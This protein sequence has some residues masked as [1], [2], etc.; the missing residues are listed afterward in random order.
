MYPAQEMID[1]APSPVEA[2]DGPAAGA[3]P[4]AGTRSGAAPGRPPRSQEM[5]SAR[6]S[7]SVTV[8]NFPGVRRLMRDDPPL[9][10]TGRENIT[11]GKTVRRRRATPRQPVGYN[12]G[13]MNPDQFV[14]HL[15][16]V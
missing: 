13:V 8:A 5:P 3:A 12:A 15:G 2:P 9:E 4:A 16:E 10:E 6:P 7:A 14:S 11:G 1:S